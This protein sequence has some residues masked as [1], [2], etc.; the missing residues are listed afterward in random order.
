LIYFNVLYYL[1]LEIL[2]SLFSPTFPNPGTA[3]LT[4]S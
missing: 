4:P 2:Q 3:V 1:C